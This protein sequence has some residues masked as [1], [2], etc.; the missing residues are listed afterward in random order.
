M[1]FAL[2]LTVGFA[3]FAMALADLLTVGFVVFALA[4][5]DLLT[6]GFVVFAVTFNAAPVKY[7]ASPRSLASFRVTMSTDCH[8]RLGFFHAWSA[9]DWTVVSIGSKADR[10]KQQAKARD[11]ARS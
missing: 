5:A 3:V 11:L 10:L 4:F 8:F 2:L 6:V 7:R 1:A 9:V